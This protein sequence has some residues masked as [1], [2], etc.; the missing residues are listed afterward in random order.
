MKAVPRNQEQEPVRT[1]A[2]LIRSGEL[3][4]SHGPDF[5]S[6]YFRTVAAAPAGEVLPEHLFGVNG[7]Q[8][9][10]QTSGADPQLATQ[11]FDSAW[12]SMSFEQRLAA[13]T[14]NAVARYYA[15]GIAETVSD[16][17]LKAKRDTGAVIAKNPDIG[18]LTLGDPVKES[19]E[20]QKKLLGDFIQPAP[21]LGAEL[22]LVQQE[23][24]A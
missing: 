1:T 2:P 7:W 17:M 16:A 5:Q 23:G 10:L 9:R 20:Y 4:S 3:F 13:V 11:M 19:E 21:N 24:E 18:F 22:D 15:P 6:E 8:R 12:N 14:G